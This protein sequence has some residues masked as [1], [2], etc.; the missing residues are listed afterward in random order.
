M[1]HPRQKPQQ[2]DQ[3]P[4]WSRDAAESL[5]IPEEP[6]PEQAERHVVDV[7]RLI[8]VIGLNLT[9]RRIFNAY[10]RRGIERNELAREL[11]LSRRQVLTTLDNIERKLR[12][13]N[14][15]RC[16][17]LAHS[18]GFA[19]HERLDS[20][21]LVWSVSPITGNESITREN[22]YSLIRQQDTKQIDQQFVLRGRTVRNFKVEIQQQIAE[23]RAKL[24]RISDQRRDATESIRRAEK[25]I[26]HLRATDLD[27]QAKAIL[28][29]RPWPDPRNESRLQELQ[30]T[31]AEATKR[32]LAASM[33]L[34]SQTEIIAGLEL[35][36]EASRI[37]S[38]ASKFKRH[39]PG[40]LKTFEKLVSQLRAL[41]SDIAV[42]GPFQLS[43]LAPPADPKDSFADL[44]ERTSFVNLL[45]AVQ[46]SNW[47]PIGY[48]GEPY[49][50]KL[51]RRIA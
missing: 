23:A 36:L 32:E 13:P 9:E 17:A 20:G 25:E 8:R 31:I 15:R 30:E 39:V 50:R 38:R 16:A 49:H 3:K 19:F 7:E 27:D 51:L 45:G 1:K 35:E 14:A 21:R 42:D 37:R 24:D 46:S 44:M 29:E 33:A 26:T 40:I 10:F 11:G 6:T 43:E 5:G 48:E 18:P 2:F 28:E 12:T 41:D 22:F 47:P 34:K 4:V